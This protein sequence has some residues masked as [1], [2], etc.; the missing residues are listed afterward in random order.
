MALQPIPV[1]RLLT[2]RQVAAILNVSIDTL[3]K[4]ER[5]AKD[6]PSLNWTAGPSVT[7]WRQSSST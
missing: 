6:Q 2:T 4:C 7:D 3:K 5:A 1:E